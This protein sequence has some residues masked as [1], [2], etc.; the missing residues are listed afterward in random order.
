MNKRLTSLLISFSFSLA[1]MAQ[2]TPDSANLLK[3]GDQMPGFTVTKMDGSGFS[4]DELK[5]KTVLINFFATWC[6]PCRKELPEVETLIH[7]KYKDRDDFVLLIISREEAPEKVIPFIESKD[8]P[9]D[10]YSD[11]DLSCYAQ[12][13]LKFIPRNYVFDKTGKLVYA[14]KGFNQEEFE[15]MVNKIESLLGE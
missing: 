10:F 7:D 15:A 14:S 4:S 6:P 13:A 8:Y 5:N 12:F 1:L 3:L 9:M 11:I 2:E